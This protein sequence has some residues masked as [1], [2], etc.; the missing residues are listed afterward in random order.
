MPPLAYPSHFGRRARRA[1]ASHYMPMLDYALGLRAFHSAPADARPCLQTAPPRRPGSRQCLSHVMPSKPFHAD[2]DTLRAFCRIPR[3]ARSRRCLSAGFDDAYVAP[4]RTIAA[5]M[6]LS[7]ISQMPEAFA[8]DIRAYDE[9]Q[10]KM[11]L[12]HTL[13]ASQSFSAR[14]HFRAIII[15]ASQLRHDTRSLMPMK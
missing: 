6:K 15:L 5:V 1:R 8:P 7:D 10:A 13:P 3:P 4:M 11:W 14:Q 9:H 12:V 2:F